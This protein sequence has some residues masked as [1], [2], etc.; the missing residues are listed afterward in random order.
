MY[1]SFYPDSATTAEIRSQ[2]RDFESEAELVSHDIPELLRS[3]SRVIH[4]AASNNLVPSYVLRDWVWIGSQIRIHQ[5]EGGDVRT[6]V[7]RFVLY[8][9]AQIGPEED[10]GNIDL[11][12]IRWVTAFTISVLL[13]D[14]SIEGPRA[15]MSAD[16][17]RR[18]EDFWLSLYENDNIEISQL[19]EEVESYLKK[20]EDVASECYLP[21]LS[22]RVRELLR[23]ANGSE[24]QSL[25]A[26]A[27]LA[28][29]VVE[30]DIVPDNLGYFGLVDDIFV[31]NQAFAMCCHQAPWLFLLDSFVAEW[32]DLGNLVIGDDG[33]FSPLPQ[34]VQAVVGSALFGLEHGPATTCLTIPQTG[35]VAPCSAFFAALAAARKRQIAEPLSEEL[36]DG[37]DVILASANRKVRARYRGT[38]EHEGE[39]FHMVELAQGRRAVRDEYLD[40][41]HQVLTPHRTLSTSNEFQKWQD[42]FS[43]VL[44]EQLL[45]S[46]LRLDDLVPEVLLVTS[47]K[48]LERWLQTF[49]PLG[50][51]V[52]E[53][54][55]VRY[56]MRS[57]L[58][59]DLRG[60]IGTMPLLVACNDAYTAAE[61]LRSDDEE[62][63]CRFLKWVIVDVAGFGGDLSEL[64]LT[65]GDNESIKCVFV[66][67]LENAEVCQG[68]HA[69]GAEQ[70][71]VS[72]DDVGVMGPRVEAVL[73]TSATSTYMEQIRIQ[74]VKRSNVIEID[75][76]IVQDL[77]EST[78]AIQKTATEQ[79][80]SAFEILAYTLR[81]LIRKLTRIYYPLDEDE[82]RDL[83][84][85]INSS[86][87][88]ANAVKA[89][90]A[91]IPGLVN[92]LERL[93]GE[94]QILRRK[95]IRIVEAQREFGL[96][97][98]TLFCES[99]A[100]YD[101]LAPVSKDLFGLGRESLVTLQDLRERS[102][103]DCLLIPGWFDKRQMR[104]LRASGFAE[105]YWLFLYPF[106]HEWEKTSSKAQRRWVNRL[107]EAT[108]KFGKRF[109][110]KYKN[111]ASAERW[112]E[113]KPVVTPERE[114]S[115]EVADWP[116]SEVV[117]A[118]S[119]ERAKASGRVETVSARMILFDDPE[120]FALLSPG[121]RAICLPEVL[122]ASGATVDSPQQ[123]AESILSRPIS[124]I[125]TGTVLAFPISSEGD[126]LDSLADEILQDSPGVRRLA[127]VWRVSLREYMAGHGVDPWSLTKKLREIGVER[128]VATVKHWL[129]T[130]ETIAPRAWRK[131][132]PLI[133]Q[134]TGNVELKNRFSLVSDAINRIYQARRDAADQLVD[135]LRTGK[136]DFEH[137]ILTASI[138]EKSIEY[139]VLRVARIESKT[140][141]AAELVGKLL[142]IADLYKMVG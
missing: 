142:S 67:G 49:R 15:F 28:Y 102:P 36:H 12:S 5:K 87:S 21:D 37:D 51:R 120:Y 94:P 106:E 53:L 84:A 16:E 105:S 34:Y 48:K 26:A 7:G 90:D 119:Q 54:L 79:G 95:Y 81:Q 108:S 3:F 71:L 68:L 139:R 42:E 8:V 73:P 86:M 77:Y 125:R 133:G 93:N 101:R 76:E 99:K 131:E 4:F 98:A 32:T 100:Q 10:G 136:V 134:L 135:Q 33:D 43:P 57:G 39:T 114:A 45:R 40:A 14:L 74:R 47:K 56:F 109:E 127:G 65:L 138:G 23:I 118:L 66:A 50:K 122:Q 132:L 11:P 115:E 91:G 61:L 80:N 128:H 27:A 59:E 1:S 25:W 72:P 141:V 64:M 85:I 88:I 124:E 30:K 9:A 107:T 78:L 24:E 20:F 96:K 111:F 121:G 52:S 29:L 123:S 103:S 18:A 75:G 113:P 62:E 83:N 6:V 110:R 55:G 46:K 2:L 63:G 126:L 116:R 35:L 89:Y 70:L 129:Y 130:D 58:W 22:N 19:A 13:D 31:L 41:M 112:P 117:A 17:R 97:N 82:E 69:K 92:T 140:E 104:E 60:S 38:T 44:I 137:G